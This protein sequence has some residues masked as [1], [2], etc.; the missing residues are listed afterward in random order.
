MNSGI[1][2]IT[3]D[4][5]DLQKAIEFYETGL[6]LPRIAVTYISRSAQRIYNSNSIK[7]FCLTRQ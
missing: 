6:G 1:S 5:N 4:I 2:M 7:R 3:L